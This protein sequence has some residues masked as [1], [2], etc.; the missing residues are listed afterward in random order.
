MRRKTIY[1]KDYAV[2][3]RLLVEAREKADLTQV[4]LSRHLPFTQSEISKIERGQRRLDIIELKM[5]C[6]RLGVRLA[7]FAAEL[8]KRLR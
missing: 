3:L 8:E 1:S 5:I 2:F 4:A 7:D 6:D